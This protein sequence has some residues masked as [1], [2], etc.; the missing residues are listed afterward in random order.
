MLSWKMHWDH[1]C[2]GQ[3]YS[4][5]FTTSGAFTKSAPVLHCSTMMTV[6]IQPSWFLAAGDNQH[7]CSRQG[8]TLAQS[9]FEN[10]YCHCCHCCLDCFCCC[11]CTDMR[12]KMRFLISAQ[13]PD[14]AERAAA[15]NV[16]K[17]RWCSSTHSW[18]NIEASVVPGPAAPLAPIPCKS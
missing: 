17:Y 1:S 6:T 11:C 18:K 10:N 13:E 14:S 16:T 9:N 4:A 2:C 5:H 15:T 12:Q 3:P 8:L 7:S